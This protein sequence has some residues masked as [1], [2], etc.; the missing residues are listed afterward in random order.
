MAETNTT[1]AGEEN[2]SAEAVSVE[3]T[4]ETTGTGTETGKSE[5]FTD[6]PE[7]TDTEA[8]EATAPASEAEHKAL[9]LE[10]FKLPDGATV[11]DELKASYLEI[12]NDEKLTRQEWGQKMID[13]YHAQQVKMLDALKAARI[14]ETKKLDAEL[15][16]LNEQ[17]DKECAGDKEFGGQDWEKNQEVISRGCKYLGEGFVKV[18]QAYGLNH[19]PDIV[20]GVYRAGLLAGEDKSQIA[21]NGT[22]KGIDPAM[23]IFGASMKE[24]REKKG[25]NK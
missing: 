2:A 8:P 3:G 5:L 19:N 6:Y 18:M 24:Y 15:K 10:D 13:L 21:G 14:E 20:R 22:S 11:N 23:S 1:T 12:L 7:D 9:T 17:W 16:A 4:G 25:A